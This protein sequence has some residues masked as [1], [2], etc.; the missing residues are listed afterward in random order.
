V[1]GLCQVR[2]E[3]FSVTNLAGAC[4]V[5]DGLDDLLRHVIS[6]GEFDLGFRKEVHDILSAAVQFRVAALA[7]KALYFGNGYSLNTDI[8]DGFAN[9]VQFERL[10]NR[11]NH[12]HG[13]SP[14]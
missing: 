4:R 8:S 11:R 13:Y 9:V 5:G 10:N 1:N 6:D 14:V 3:D 12:L 7:A 2:D